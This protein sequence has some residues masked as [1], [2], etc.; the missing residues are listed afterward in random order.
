MKNKLIVIAA[1]G[2][3]AIKVLGR[4]KSDLRYPLLLITSLPKM[5]FRYFV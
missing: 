1:L 2:W 3:V 4:T 5:A